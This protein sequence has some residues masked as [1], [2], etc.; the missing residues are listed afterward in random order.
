M[1][2]INQLLFERLQPAIARENKKIT[3]EVKRLYKT[4][5]IMEVAKQLGLGQR[6]IQ[7]YLGDIKRKPGQRSG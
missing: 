3:K 7:G 4:H 6:A 1:A 2:N 5:T